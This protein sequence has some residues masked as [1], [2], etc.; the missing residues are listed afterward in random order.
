MAKKT[1]ALLH[2]EWDVVVDGQFGLRPVTNCGEI[3]DLLRAQV[4]QKKQALASVLS[5][6][7]SI[8]GKPT[9]HRRV[10][11]EQV[12]VQT[13]AALAG[14][15]WQNGA[16]AERAKQSFVRS[17]SRNE[18][19]DSEIFEE[20]LRLTSRKKNPMTVE[21]AAAEVAGMDDDDGKPSFTDRD[22]GTHRLDEGAIKAAFY[23]RKK[24]LAEAG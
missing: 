20:M 8:C 6:I 5:A 10:K 11:L 12:L 19:R 17:G 13:L 18:Q 15:S 21:Q 24:R 4:D 22:D 1:F 14:G 23:R 2:R 7:E 16:L 3:N 9:K